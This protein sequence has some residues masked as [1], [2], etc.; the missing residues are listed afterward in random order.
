MEPSPP[1]GFSLTDLHMQVSTM[2]HLMRACNHDK[3]V[4][5][6]LG[7]GRPRVLS[8]LAVYGASTQRDIA[9]YFGIDAAAVSRM[10]DGLVRDGFVRIVPGRDRRCRVVELTEF[11]CATLSTWDRWCADVD[12]VML[13]GFSDEERAAVTDMLDRICANMRAHLGKNVVDEEDT[14]PLE[15]EAAHE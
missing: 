10:L 2:F 4:E 13:E 6:G 15:T 11:G 12:E 3:V 7:P 8:Y 9:R 1:F 5:L 14:V